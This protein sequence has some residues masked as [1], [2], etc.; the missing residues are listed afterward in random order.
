MIVF[1][2]RGAVGFGFLGLL[3]RRLFWFWVDS[4]VFWGDLR[5]GLLLQSFWAI[6]CWVGCC[7]L[8]VVWGFGL[9]VALVGRLV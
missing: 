4:F 8:V 2:V 5:V 7:R 9:V 3:L 1:P 6:W